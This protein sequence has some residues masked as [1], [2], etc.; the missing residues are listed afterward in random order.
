[1]QTPSEDL[2]QPVF[3]IDHPDDYGQFQLTSPQEIA[4]YLQLLARQRNIVTAYIDAGRQ[5]FL[6]TILAVDE[7]SRLIFLDPPQTQESTAAALGARRLTL[8]TNL[9]R[10]KMQVRLATPQMHSY[11]GQSVLGAAFPSNMLRLQ[12]RE[13]FRLEPPLAHPIHCKLAAPKADGSAQTF[14]LTLSDISGGGV[15]LKGT[16]DMKADFPRDALFQDCRL[17][18]P[19]EG[20]ILVNLRVRKV[21][22]ISAQHGP[23][24]LRIGCE[25]VNLPGSRLAFI[26]RYITR[27]ERER[28]A[29]AS[30]LSN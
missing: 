28:K 12:R 1:M 7:S 29:H 24:D 22:E 23:H 13:F 14:E 15:S 26:E 8:V 9:D 19:G 17:E 3:E 6:S 18:I 25:F 4:F 30:G 10:V 27:I 11:Q 21:I 16:T 2:P 20:V 5:F